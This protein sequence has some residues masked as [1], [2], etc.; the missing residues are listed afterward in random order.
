MRISKLKEELSGL[1]IKLEDSVVGGIQ[2]QVFGILLVLYG[3][4]VGTFL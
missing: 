2:A 4:T 1:S 3:A